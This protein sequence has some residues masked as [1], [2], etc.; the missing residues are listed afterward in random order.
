MRSLFSTYIDCYII[1][2]VQLHEDYEF[3]IRTSIT[4]D[5]TCSVWFMYHNNV[6]LPI[7]SLDAR[8]YT[9]RQ[10]R[11]HVFLLVTTDLTLRPNN[12]C[13]VIHVT[14]RSRCKTDIYGLT[15]FSC[16]FMFFCTIESYCILLSLLTVRFSSQF[17]HGRRH[18]Y[19]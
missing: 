9:E 3:L 19:L 5:D 1:Y 16:S 17:Q 4:K 2:Y 7:H 11:D 8:K 13:C 12:K 14:F 18:G 10:P 6:Y 15:I